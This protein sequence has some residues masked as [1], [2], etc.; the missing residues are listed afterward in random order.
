MNYLL[1]LG[2]MTFL[3]D[4]HNTTIMHH[5][6][7]VEA[8]DDL[9]NAQTVGDLYMGEQQYI[10]LGYYEGKIVN[11]IDSIPSEDDIRDI[12]IRITDNLVL[13]GLIKNCLD[14]DDSIE[15]DVQDV[16]SDVLK[17]VIA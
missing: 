7:R 10:V 16:I 13:Q 6:D 17:D 3:H 1:I 12:A 4:K 2:E 11:T 15:F 5:I 8:Y 9:S 14:T